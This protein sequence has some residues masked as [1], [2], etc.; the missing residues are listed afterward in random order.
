MTFELN[1]ARVM[2]ILVQ[3]YSG[4]IMLH[5][6]S[7]VETVSILNWVCMIMVFGEL[8]KV[9]HTRVNDLGVLIIIVHL[10]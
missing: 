5:L 2:K 3:H 6:P 7:N 8:V 10:A 9:T 1:C 4:S